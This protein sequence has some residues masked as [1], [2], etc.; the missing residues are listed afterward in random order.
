MKDYL[1]YQG[2]FQALSKRDLEALFIK[3]KDYRLK[4]HSYLGIDSKISF[5]V[6]LEFQDVLLY[7]VKKEL[8]KDERFKGWIIHEDKSCTYQID[9]FAVGGEISSPILHDIDVD[10]KILA[11]VLQ[12]L[13]GLKARVTEET[14]FQVHVGAQIFEQDI[15]NVVNFVKLWCVF[16][17]VIFKFSYGK[18]AIYRP[19]I[20]YFA[21]PIADAT[22]L[23]CNQIPMFLDRLSCP[24]KLGYDKKWTLNFQNYSVLSVDE[25]VNNDIEIRCANGLLDKNMIQNTIYF[26]L[27]LM[28]YVMSDSFNEDY[29]NYLF[30]HLQVKEFKDY[31]KTYV[32]DVLLLVDLIFDNSLDKINFLKQYIK[33][34]EIVFVR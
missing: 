28:L 29:I 2:D 21:H 27:K 10:W 7:Y 3:L 1:N 11:E 5:G 19:K 18:D 9:D 16:E 4:Y 23:K 22:K 20:L 32:R 8:S 6:E 24:K 17:H 14:A 25:E 15:R 13:N 34:D 30:E 33:K 26:Y 12:R 31:S